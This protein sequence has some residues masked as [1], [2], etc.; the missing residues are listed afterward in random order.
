MGE[1]G[2]GAAGRTHVPDCRRRCRVRRV[3][4]CLLALFIMLIQ[5]SHL[6]VAETLRGDT[7]GPGSSFRPALGP[8]SPR[9]GPGLDP[10]GCTIGTAWLWPWPF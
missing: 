10:T 6:L 9:L 3:L 1:G 2:V 7:C 4:T 8:R 5:R